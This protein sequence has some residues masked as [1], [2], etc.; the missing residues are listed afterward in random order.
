[1]L[2][3][4]RL[5][6]LVPPLDADG[7]HIRLGVAWAALT[8]LAAAV[9]V[10]ALAAVMAVA[11]LGAAGQAARSWRRSKPKRTPF[12]PVAIGGAVLIALAGAGGP[13]AVVVAAAA[14][15][16][17]ALVAGRARVGRRRS[18]TTLTAAISLLV[19]GGAA[20]PTVALQHLGFV[21]VL[22]LLLSVHAFD[23]SVYVIGTGGRRWVGVVAGI[24]A[25]GA[26]SL[27][28]AGVFAPPFRGSAPWVLG[29]LLAVTLPFG[30]VV[31]S[32]L[33]PSARVTVPALRRIDSLL[34]AAPVWLVV[35]ALTLAM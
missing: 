9:G 11:A 7:P 15:G 25:V 18:D 6:A 17:A 5:G 10:V 12:R 19:G 29:G 35:A 26:L 22:V 1:M 31:A 33:V 13:V 27:F 3:G 20:A 28:A 8:V 32:L 34:V 24:A 21:A 4:P 16:V 14:V 23:A 2:H 30:P